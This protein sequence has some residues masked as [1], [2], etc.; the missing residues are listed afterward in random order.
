M[1]SL[2]ISEPL[3]VSYFDPFDEP[4]RSA[5]AVEALKVGVIA[6]Q[7][8]RPT[9]DS[10]VVRDQFSEMQR[11]FG[12][13][14]T[15]YFAEKDGIVPRSLN[16]AFGEKG[17]LSQ[18]FQRYFDPESGRVARLMDGQIGPSS[19]FARLLD[20]KNKEGVIAVIEDKVR[21]LVDAKLNEVLS[22]F[23]LDED[24]SAMSRLKAMIDTAFNGLRVALNVK[25]ARAEEAER[26]HVKGI[27]FE[28]DLYGFVA[29]MA[30]QAG[31]ES[32]LVRGTQGT[33]KCKKG[34]HLITLG[35]ATGAPGL[36]I[37]LEAKDQQYSVK[38]AAAELLE[39]KKNRD[40]VSGIFVFA[41]GC[42]PIE[43]G[44][45]K[46]IE[47]DYY[48]TVD[49][50]TMAESGRLLFLEVAYELARLQAVATVR[51][52]AGGKFDLDRVQ[53]QIDGIADCVPRLAEIVTKANTVQNA[54]K[55]IE[56]TAK[57]VKDD[58]EKRSGHLL[59][60][61]RLEMD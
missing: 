26:G 49:K 4:D 42:E 45:F 29:K 2:D 15:R 31:D 35:E 60:L 11:D 24:G 38:K 18:F 3:L 22:E 41:K 6:L 14:L 23:S 20:P 10:Q 8:A 51:K 12:Q 33:L 47:N 39:A 55:T 28:E 1:L 43:F 21:Q 36:R 40:A 5:K 32:E 52:A 37:V 17:S 27:N 56:A 50:T 16:D 57:D 7:T 46:R 58:I 34:D 9:L 48:C 61:L 30:G 53:Q 25:A 44:N 54:G 13:A 19:R 59:A